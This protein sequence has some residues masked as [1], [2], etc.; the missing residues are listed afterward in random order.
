MLNMFTVCCMYLSGLWRLLFVWACITTC[1]K[2]ATARP[3][4]SHAL[5]TSLYLRALPLDVRAQVCLV[6]V[7]VHHSF[8][9]IHKICMRN[10]APSWCVSR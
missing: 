8:V 3:T 2:A 10:T 1:S 9:Y 4:L 6:F 5:Q 7:G